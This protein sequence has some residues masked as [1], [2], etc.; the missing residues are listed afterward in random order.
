[1]KKLNIVTKNAQQ[2]ND[3]RMTAENNIKNVL[4][5]IYMFSNIST[6]VKNPNLMVN[7]DVTQFTFSDSS[8]ELVQVVTNSEYKLEIYSTSKDCESTHGGLGIKYF[9]II[10]ASGLSCSTPVYVIADGSMDKDDC[11]TYQVLGLSSDV[12]NNVGYICFCKTR[13]CNNKFYLWFNNTVLIPYMKAL[14]R[15][16]CEDNG[17]CSIMCDDEHTQIQPYFTDNILKE[18]SDIN[19]IVVKL[20]VSTTDVSQPCDCYNIF[21]ALKSI[22]KSIT[23]EQ[24]N[25]YNGRVKYYFFC[26]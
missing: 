2:K 6:Y 10:T 4:S 15:N 21:K 20:S 18:L 13:A 22:L 9:A 17:W 1:M 7:F 19:C 8:Y 14:K 23:D 3:A 5:T 26:I 24:I 12:F 11:K 16:Y 25:Q